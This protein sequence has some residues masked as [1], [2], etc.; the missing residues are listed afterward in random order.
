LTESGNTDDNI[1]RASLQTC[2]SDGVRYAAWF[3]DLD[4]WTEYWD[5]YHPDTHGRFYFGDDKNEKGLLSRFLPRVGK[6]P[7]I[8]TAWKNMALGTAPNAI[9]VEAACSPAVAEAVAE[10]DDLLNR[11]FSDHF[12]DPRDPSV[13]EDYLEAIFRFSTDTLPA[14]NERYAKIAQEDLRKRTAGRHTLDG[15][16]M[17]FAW[18]L[19]TEAAEL[20]ASSEAHARRALFLAGIATGC[21][22]NFAWRGHRRTRNEYRPSA[23]TKT[24]L[25]QRGHS[26]ASDSPAAADE[27]HALFRIREWGDY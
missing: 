14:A 13:E 20:V 7:E 4:A 6:P 15:D 8:F 24:L 17:W 22:A 18:A 21:P 27:I 25:R 9:F 26:W 11:L 3:H 19:H 23:A 10:V 5:I 16:I 1:A 2:D 12:G